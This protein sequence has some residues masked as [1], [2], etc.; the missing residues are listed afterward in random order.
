MLLSQIRGVLTLNSS[1]ALLPGR[2][3]GQVLNGGNNFSDNLTLDSTSNAT[4]G[5]V[6]INPYDGNVGIGLAGT[7]T[8][9]PITK[10]DV[11][12]AITSRPY[13]SSTGQTG[14]L[15]LNELTAN[16][17]NNIA[18]R[19]PDSIAAN[20]IITLPTNSGS[21]GQFLT[22]DGSGMTSW[23]TP[24]PP[25]TVLAASGSPTSPSIAFSSDTNT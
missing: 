1:V 20:Y 5:N 13:G 21:A 16:G 25:A 19:A 3:G 18:I 2:T 6:L 9:N 14:Q 24:T 23:T 4:K 12:G 17:I 15:V 11:G 8:P 22:T 7:G 10:L